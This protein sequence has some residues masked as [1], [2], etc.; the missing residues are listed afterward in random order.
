[1]TTL[2]PGAVCKLSGF[3]SRLWIAKEPVADHLGEFTRYRLICKRLDHRGR[4]DYQTHIAG[5]HD[6]V[7]VHD[8]ETYEVGSTVRYAG[9]DHLV[10][11]DLGDDGVEL[12]VP[13][14]GVKT[15]G[16]NII[17][18]PATNVRVVQKADLLLSEL[19]TTQGET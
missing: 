3:G 14:H 13:E 15:K 10:L 16:G 2:S 1:M 5:I 11:A 18:I 4:S 19:A 7:V 9:L 17:R 6:V 12:G 8:A